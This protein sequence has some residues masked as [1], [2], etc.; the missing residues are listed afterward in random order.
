[1]FGIA[2]SGAFCA[3]ILLF[4]AP[5]G[6]FTLLIAAAPHRGLPTLAVMA[7]TIAALTALCGP[8]RRG[9]AQALA[10]RVRARRTLARDLR[11]VAGL[12][13]VGFGRRLLR[14]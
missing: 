14:D 6:T 11:R 7:P 9:G 12:F 3:A 10:Q 8:L 2:D 1:M 13:P 5:P 4:L